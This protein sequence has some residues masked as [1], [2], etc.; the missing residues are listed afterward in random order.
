MNWELVTPFEL[1][2]GHSKLVNIQVA[3]NLN[4]KRVHFEME[5]AFLLPLQEIISFIDHVVF[6]REANSYAC[7]FFHQQGSLHIF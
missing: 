3:R 5:F 2:C 7:G 6:Y 1:S 4:L